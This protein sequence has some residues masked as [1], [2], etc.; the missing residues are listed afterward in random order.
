MA[1]FNLDP[2][3][4]LEPI[5]VHIGSTAIGPGTFNLADAERVDIGKFES[6]LM[7]CADGGGTGTITITPEESDTPSGTKTPL[8]G[9]G[10]MPNF[11]VEFASGEFELKHRVIRCT[12][13]RQ[14]LNINIVVGGAAAA[15]PFVAFYGVRRIQASGASIEA[16]LAP[17]QA[18]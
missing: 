14:F 16:D 8:D 1:H 2:Q 5:A 9:T 4:F 17:L 6:V 7:A 10:G 11:V 18:S 13:R 12:G 15:R 3:S